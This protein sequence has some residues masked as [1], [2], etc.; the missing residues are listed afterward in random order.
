MTYSSFDF[1]KIDPTLA[2]YHMLAVIAPRP[3]AWVSTKSAAGVNNL[4]PF[5]FFNA[6]SADPPVLGFAPASKDDGSFKDTYTNI[7]E[8]ADCVINMVSF[9]LAQ[10][11]NISSQATNQDEF[12]L[13]NLTAI[14]STLVKSPRVAEA[15]VQIEARLLE[16][17]NFRKDASG[18]TRL[19]R[20]QDSKA[21]T[22]GTG[23]LIICEALCLHIRNDLIKDGRIDT[24]SLDLIG[25]N[26]R[27]YY[28]RAN[29]DSMFRLP[30][31]VS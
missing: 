13:A 15:P 20:H 22:T 5:S 12:K 8:T 16:I 9:D 30:K 10:Q 7:A 31:S 1:S 25:R 2:Y 26:G 28:T 19:Y 23:N 11:M 21:G 4:A 29:A 3:I 24:V 27:D 18:K 17:I 14:D 6:F